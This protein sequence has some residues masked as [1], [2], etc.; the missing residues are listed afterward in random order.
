MNSYRAYALPFPDLFSREYALPFAVS[1]GLHI[2]LLLLLIGWQFHT[3]TRHIAAPSY[4]KA[5]LVKVAPQ[6]KV[7]TPPAPTVM[8]PVEIFAPPSE[9]VEKPKPESRKTETLKQEKQQQEKLKQQQLEHKKKEEQERAA[10][11][12]AEAEKRR[13]EQK[14]KAE[15]ALASEVAAEEKYQREVVDNQ[16]AQSYANLIKQR[17]EQNWSRPPS[18][19]KGMEVILEIQLVPAG[20]VTGVTV[21]QSSGNPAFDLSA[22]Q[23]VQK[24]ERFTEIKD[25]PAGV[26]EANFRHFQLKFRP[27]DKL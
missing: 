2:L 20:Y 17:V 8:V 12:N 18:T 23:A 27:D 13:L 19:R 22:Q 3:S 10:R 11:E 24:V 21:L 4:L 16:V 7:E 5:K 25:M 6:V 1:A 14:R 15:E 26:F 9:V